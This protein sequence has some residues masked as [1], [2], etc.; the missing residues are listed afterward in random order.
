MENDV[1][2]A[3]KQLL[4]Q[5]KIQEK[6]LD[7]SDVCKL[8]GISKSTLYKMNLRNAIPFFKPK[9]GKK[10]YYIEKD[11][12]DYITGIRFSSKQELDE[13]ARMSNNTK[14]F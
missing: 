6:Y 10:L 8:L 5:Q 3:I 2:F 13:R 11:V 9:N 1:V 4:S 7:S 14:E 12:I